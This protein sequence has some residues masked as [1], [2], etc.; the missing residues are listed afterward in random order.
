ML[1][2]KLN[3]AEK[4]KN[5]REG[6]ASGKL[7]QFPGAFNPLCAQLIESKGFDGVYISGAVMA[8][9]LCLPDIGLA[10]MTEFVERGRQTA[11]VTDLPAFI[12]IDT[13]FGEPMSAARTV[14]M[15]EE[16]GLSGCHIEDQVMPKR[17][18]HLDGK[19]IV[20]TDVMIQRVKAAAEAKR[21]PNFVLIARSDARAVEGLDQAIDRMKA[22]VDAGADMIFPE[23]MKDEKEFEAVRKAL[24]VPILANMTEFGKSRLLNKKE[25][26]N[27][28]FNVVIYP[29]T[30][31]RLA[32]G[33]AETGLDAI[34]R[35]G[36]QNGVLNIMQHRRDL[37]D[38]L[39]YHEY[40]KFDE[41]IYNFQVGDTP[42]K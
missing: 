19:E 28:G 14:M 34:L 29:V 23:A 7:L 4:R 6:L 10:T 40:N 15:M 24:D 5:F 37:Y 25:L 18:G 33:A 32:M 9:D 20:A 21:D 27:L 22:Y 26:E 36:D 35:D 16:A 3:A 39:H 41:S 1:F 13:G 17:C 42:M 31:L 11:R 38:L 8:A 2:T 30:T 12:D